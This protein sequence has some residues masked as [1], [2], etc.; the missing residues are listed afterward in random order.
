MINYTEE[1]FRSLIRAWGIL[2][3]KCTN[4]CYPMR[5]DQGY[6]IIVDASGVVSRIKLARTTHLSE[7]GDYIVHLRKGAGKEPFDSSRCEFLFVDSPE[8]YYLI[9]SVM[10]TQ[11]STITL[12]KFK[13]YLITQ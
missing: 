2:C 11:K 12:S 4:I 10:I 7:K 1:N 9:P 3:R 5:R 6:D 8:G 13:E